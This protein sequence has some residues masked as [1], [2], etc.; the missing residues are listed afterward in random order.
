MKY[1]FD[2]SGSFA[3]KNPGPHIMVGIAYPEVFEN[4][5]KIFYDEFIKSLKPN[6]FEKGEPKGQ[7]LLFE[8]REKLFSFLKDNSWLNISVSLTDSEFNSEY[9]INQYRIE[10]IDYYKQQLVDPNYKCKSVELT[11]LLADFNIKGGLSDVQINKGLLLMHTLLSL[12]IGSLKNFTGEVYDNDWES[13]LI[14]FDRLDK[15][16]I[17][18]MEDWVMRDFINLFTDYSI[19]N[20]I[21]LN[22]NWFTRNHPVLINFR[23]DNENSL[24]LN[25]M[26]KDKFLFESSEK[27]FQLQIV[28]WISNSLFKVIKKE[29]S[30]KFLDMIEDNLIKYNNAKI[31]VVAFGS[32]NSL[33]LLNKYKDFLQ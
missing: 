24:D 11:K 18:K 26:F 33:T 27:C 19:K 9:Q 17:T 32:T 15:N 14:C 1:F 7:L 8:S 4:K 25:K 21:E 5:F 28:D 2:E 12:L 22:H 31:R 10:Q 13:F 30:H 16:T 29:F 3:V 20:N 23:I 6:E